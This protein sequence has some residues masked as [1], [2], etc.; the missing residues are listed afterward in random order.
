M[1]DRSIAV[2]STPRTFPRVPPAPVWGTTS[3]LISDLG[4]GDGPV[5][6]LLACPELG[7]LPDTL[8][9][10]ADGDLII[11]QTAAAAV[12]PPGDHI[13]SAAASVCYGLSR[14]GVR[15]LIVCG[16]DDCRL[17]SSINR[18]QAARTN[19]L[20][21]RACGVSARPHPAASAAIAADFIRRQLHNLQRYEEVRAKLAAGQL[22]LHAWMLDRGTARVRTL[23]R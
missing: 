8:A 6:V 12:P 4:R 10:A 19:S 2:Q 1:S 16:H 15:H 21:C 9:H 11:V 5:A 3:E 18:M 23:L 13:G 14:P 7:G 17:L 20:D 22:Q